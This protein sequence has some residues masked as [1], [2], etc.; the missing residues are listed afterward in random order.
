MKSQQTVNSAIQSLK[1]QNANFSVLLST[2]TPEG[3]PP[4][5]KQVKDLQKNLGLKSKSDSDS[6]EPISLTPFPRKR[7]PETL[8][9]SDDE[10]A[11]VNIEV[12]ILI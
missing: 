7:R 8:L 2:F 11:S 10:K 9:F 1:L 4:I 6:P 12:N 3:A 5:E